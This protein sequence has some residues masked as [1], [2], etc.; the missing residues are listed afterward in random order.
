MAFPLK[1]DAQLALPLDLAFMTDGI[2]NSV[3]EDKLQLAKFVQRMDSV[4]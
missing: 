2:F 4:L 1:A 3:G